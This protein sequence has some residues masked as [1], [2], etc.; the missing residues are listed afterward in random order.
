MYSTA[1]LLTCLTS[2]EGIRDLSRLSIY[3]RCK[4]GAKAMALVPAVRT[5]TAIDAQGLCDRLKNPGKSALMWLSKRC[6]IPC[7]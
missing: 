2:A 6:A 7:R 4:S 3:G 5:D 1:S